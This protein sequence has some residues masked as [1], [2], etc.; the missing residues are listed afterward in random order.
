MNSLFK[1]LPACGVCM[2]TLV[3][4]LAIIEPLAAAST[5]V[6]EDGEFQSANWTNEVRSDSGLNTV[7][8][9]I[10]QVASGGIPG[11]YRRIGYSMDHNGTLTYGSLY[12]LNIFE[13][14]QYTPSVQGAVNFVNYFEQQTRLSATWGPSMVGAQP[15]IFQG[16]KVFVGPGFNFG[17][18]DNSWTSHS[19]S[20]LVASDFKELDGMTAILTSHPDFSLT[21]SAMKFGYARSNS[22]SF[23]AGISHGID[24][25]SYTLNVTPIPEPSSLALGAGFLGLA[26]F[27]RVR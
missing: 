1:N 27:R 5:V 19:D 2:A 26:L 24:N 16:G 10:T 15:L 13:A 25:W 4:Q 7:T 21:G 12:V 22:T 8:A 18:N 9:T 17:P 20:N 23:D 11:S 14:V 3:G 6:I